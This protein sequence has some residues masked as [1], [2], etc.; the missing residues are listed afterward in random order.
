MSLKNA[1]YYRCSADEVLH[2]IESYLDYSGITRDSE[3]RDLDA[4]V[5]FEQWWNDWISD[6]TAE[7][8]GEYKEQT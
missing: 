6:E 2:I 3:E 5:M 8:G 7:V 4:L 1:T